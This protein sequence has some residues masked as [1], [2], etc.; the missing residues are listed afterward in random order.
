[1]ARSLIICW[2][3]A[4][5]LDVMVK[6]NGETF[7]GSGIWD[8]SRILAAGPCT[9]I[10]SLYHFSITDIT[11]HPLFTDEPEGDMFLGELPSVIR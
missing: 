6:K 8:R 2:Q 3:L 1:M 9:E 7:T 10:N 11:G 5:E 4:A